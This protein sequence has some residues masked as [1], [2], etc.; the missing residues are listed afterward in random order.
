MVDIRDLLA[1]N[2]AERR[3]F[4]KAF[5]KLSW[6]EFTK[7]REASFHSIRNIFIHTLNATDYWLDF[8]QNENQRSKKKFEEYKTLK[9]IEAYMKHIENRMNKYVKSLSPE[10]LKKK[11]KGRKNGYETLIAEDVLVHVFEEEV[12]HRGELIALFWQIG[13][14]PPV[15]GYP[16]YKRAR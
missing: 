14:E 4:F 6:G 5:A 15:I 1:Y 7:N 11:Y 12:H 9:E 8:L 16:P 3:A 13:I 2:D 10:D